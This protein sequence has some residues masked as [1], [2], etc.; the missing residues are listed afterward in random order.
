MREEKAQMSERAKRICKVA[1]GL[2]LA[3]LVVTSAVLGVGTATA[4]PPKA[5][6]TLPP[7]DFLPGGAWIVH[8]GPNANFGAAGGCKHGQPTRGHPVYIAPATGL[9]TP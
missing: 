6:G 3:A 2:V 1:S 5:S 9:H 8:N 7:C 4:P